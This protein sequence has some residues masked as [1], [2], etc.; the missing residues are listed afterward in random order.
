[1]YNHLKLNIYFIKNKNQQNK[2]M[3]DLLKLV[4]SKSNINIWHIPE[5][6]PFTCNLQMQCLKQHSLDYRFD[7][8]TTAHKCIT[9]ISRITLKNEL[10][11]S[12]TAD[13]FII[14]QCTLRFLGR[15]I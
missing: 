5:I 2:Y 8:S 6:F 10:V 3:S 13:K 4:L 14:R 1:M 15:T 11:H 9:F 7:V 12:D